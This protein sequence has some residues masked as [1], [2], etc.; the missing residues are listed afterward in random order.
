MGLCIFLDLGMGILEFWASYG[1]VWTIYQGNQE[2][3]GV[4]LKEVFGEKC[5]LTGKNQVCFMKMGKTCFPFGTIYGWKWKVWGWDWLK[6]GK[7]LC[8]GKILFF[9]P[10]MGLSDF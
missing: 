3:L 6:P 1:S 4:P 7:F 9:G 5:V 10:K 8:R 2:V